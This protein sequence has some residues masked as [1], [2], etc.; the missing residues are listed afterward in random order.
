MEMP[1]GDRSIWLLKLLENGR[2]WTW[3]VRVDTPTS[4]VDDGWT[5]LAEPWDSASVSASD[6]ASYLA[7][8]TIGMAA[9]STI[10]SPARE[11]SHLRCQARLILTSRQRTC[12]PTA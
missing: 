1:S 7:E 4:L 12:V 10:W 8:P 5:H 2:P 11:R 3:R 6:G 9:A